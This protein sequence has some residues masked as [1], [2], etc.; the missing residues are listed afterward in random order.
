MSDTPKEKDKGQRRVYMLPSDLMERLTKYQHELGISSEAEAV[1]RLLDSALKS[2]D[3]PDKIIDRF[4]ERLKEV[5]DLSEV[6]KDVLVGH[7]HIA[8]IRFGTDTIDVKIKDGDEFQISLD[9][10]VFIESGNGRDEWQEYRTETQKRALPP[11]KR[12]APAVGRSMDLDDDIP[13]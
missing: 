6:A 12:V 11:P 4:L 9:G 13:F 5:R 10:R 7:P 2:R 1:R 8:N 3:N